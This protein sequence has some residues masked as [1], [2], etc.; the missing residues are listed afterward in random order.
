MLRK[1]K[2][3][4]AAALVFSFMANV[5]VIPWPVSLTTSTKNRESALE[6]LVFTGPT[7]FTEGN[8]DQVMMKN[9][10]NN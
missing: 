8:V 4:D 7:S 5:G 2:P 1:P 6:A 3:P 10:F 9:F